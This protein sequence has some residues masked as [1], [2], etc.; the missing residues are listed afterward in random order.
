MSPLLT[1][2]VRYCGASV[3]SEPKYQIPRA[4]AA[5]RM[6]MTSSH[7]GHFRFEL[8]AI[9]MTRGQAHAGFTR[10][11]GAELSQGTHAR[12]MTHMVLHV[13]AHAFRSPSPGRSYL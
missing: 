2:E 8:F 4:A 9:L 3:S 12:K 7:F 5:Q 11:G 1:T 10:F 6:R 13:H